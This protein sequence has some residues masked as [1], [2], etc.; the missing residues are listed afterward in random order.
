MLRPARL[1]A[2]Q[3]Q[4]EPNK[5]AI[6]SGESIVTYGMLEMGT[7]AVAHR[8]AGFGLPRGS[9]VTLSIE[10]PGRN[11]AVSLALERCGLVGAAFASQTMYA[12]LPPAALVLTD[13]PFLMPDGKQSVVVDDSWFGAIPPGGAAVPEPGSEDDY[14]IFLSSGTTGV[15]KPIVYT[16]ACAAERVVEITTALEMIGAFDRVLQ[17]F[18]VVAAGGYMGTLAALAHGKT[19]Y[20]PTAGQD[21]LQLVQVY[22][23]Q[24]IQCATQQLSGMVER[25]KQRYLPLPSLV[26]IATG[27]SIVP[28]EL[29]RDAQSLVCGRIFLAYG[30]SELL[31]TAMELVN[32]HDFEDGATGFICPW[33]EAEVVDSDRNVL[34]PGEVGELRFRVQHQAKFGGEP[35]PDGR[36]PWFYPGDVGAITPARRLIVTGRVTDLIN[37]N[38]TK[39]SPERIERFLLGCPGV[40]DAAVAGF[41]HADGSEEIRALVVGDAEFEAIRSH[42]RAILP[43][44][45]PKILVRVQS[46]ERT[47]QG[48]I[49]RDS[50][51]ALLETA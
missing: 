1:I 48:K 28:L 26:G 37:I 9:I 34:P 24:F 6:V 19:V 2:F 32:A 43:V 14:R 23:C 33:A 17:L 51:K 46:I 45:A 49:R 38:G 4:I 44:A 30:S 39:M 36:G 25:Q 16:Q 31:N 15:P 40:S 12:A 18:G 35:A 20:F 10:A 13:K 5:P 41:R 50:V 7:R 27:G 22:Q 21:P 8:I 47:A 3:A 29:I 42:V 11:L